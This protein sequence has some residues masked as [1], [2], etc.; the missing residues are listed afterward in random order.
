[1]PADAKVITAEHLETIDVPAKKVELV[2]GRLLVSEPPGFYHGVVAARLSH[3]LMNFVEARKL[4]LIVGEAGL[5]IA[6]D[7]D[8]VRAPDACFVSHARLGVKVP[9]SFAAL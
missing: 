6:P 3:A 2:R 4:G 8:P 1:M 9:W 5:K 7:P